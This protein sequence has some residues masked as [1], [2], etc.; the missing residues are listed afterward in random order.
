MTLHT[1]PGRRKNTLHAQYL[2][3][4]QVGAVLS[5]LVMIVLLNI[6]M[7]ATSSF[8]TEVI[9]QEIVQM[10]DIVQTEQQIKAPPPPRPTVPIEVPNDEV[11]EDEE[12]ELD[13]ALDLEDVMVDLEPPALP[14][15]QKEEKVIEAEIFMVVEDMPVIIGGVQS[16][17]DLV[18]YP[19][20]AHQ[21]ALEGTVVVGIVIEK[22]GTPTHIETMK[23]VHPLLDVAAM[24]AVKQI[25]FIPGKQRGQPVRVKMAIPIRFRLNG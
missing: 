9:Y 1:I 5:L 14:V 17:Y 3:S 20:M 22:D 4:I 15:P 12:F 8:E 6:P 19:A 13:V 2:I 24:D 7:Q 25:R 18:T 10:E 21:A 16:L 23:S 11:L